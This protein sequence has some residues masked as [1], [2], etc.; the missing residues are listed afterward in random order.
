MAVEKEF[1]RLG[2]YPGMPPGMPK[3]S[4]QVT[5]RGV[6]G[7]RVKLTQEEYSVYDRYHA[8]ANEALNRVIASPN[9][10]RMPEAYQA[11]LLDSVYKKFRRAANNEINM[12]I[13]RRTTVGD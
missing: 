12:M 9:Y 8:K 10:S 4:K 6:N 1:S 2:G 5:L 7:E 13:R 3:R 11:K